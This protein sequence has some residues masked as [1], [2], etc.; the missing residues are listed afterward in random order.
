MKCWFWFVRKNRSDMS[1]R[2]TE[3]HDYIILSCILLLALGLRIWGLNAPLWYDEILTL[4]THLRMPWGDMMQ[5]YSMNHHYLYSLQAK[6]IIEIFGEAS[7]SARLPA[8]VFGVAS[9]GAIWWLARDLAGRNVA[10][11]T[12]LLLAISFH[13]IWFSQSAR[14]Y[15]E[16]A[17]WG[18][19][20]MVLFLRGIRNPTSKIWFGYGA[21]LAIAVFTH[22]TGAF[23]FTAQGLIWLFVALRALPIQGARAPII[24]LPAFGYLVGAVLT[25]VLYAPVLPSLIEVTSSVG[26]RTAIDVMQEYQ[27]PIWTVVEAVRT[28]VGNLGPLVGII[29]LLVIMFACLGAAALWQNDRLLAPIVLLHI[30]LTMLL[31]TKL[32]MKIWPRFFFIDIGF[33][34]LLIVL[35]VRL[36]ASKAT[37]MTS[38]KPLY[39]FAVVA[40]V[41]VSGGLTA[42]NYIAP[43]QDLRGAYELVEARRTADDRVYAVGVGSTV[44]SDYFEADWD[45]VASTEQFNGAISEAGPIYLVVAFPTRYFRLIP[46][47][48]DMLEDGTLELVQRFPGTLGDGA[49]FVF[50]RN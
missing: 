20:S 46:E 36:V 47:M 7:W 5:T 23:F 27:N 24:I 50:R 28:G 45:N 13:H 49:V 37:E 39:A 6:V 40:M 34:M 43:K 31:L 41:I 15:T 1:E 9:I 12:A 25:L 2:Q 8:M 30:A 4:S 18:S 14:G 44:F 42:R 10:H 22:L 17:F 35:G 19:L 16:L 32:G 33:L 29:A 48:G 3:R 26:Q 38:F 11:V 21:C